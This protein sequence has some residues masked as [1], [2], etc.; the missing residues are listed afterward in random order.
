MAELALL[1]GFAA[2]GAA[3]LRARVLPSF[4]GVNA[5]LA[6]TVL[7]LAFLLW[8]AEFLGTFGLFEPVP[9]LILVIAMGFGSWTLLPRVARGGGRERTPCARPQA[10]S[11]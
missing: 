9:Y 4:S 5:L 10:P 3:R 8:A 6:T 2:L 11:P 7:A 1:I